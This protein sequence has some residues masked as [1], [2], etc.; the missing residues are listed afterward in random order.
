MQ[1]LREMLGKELNV[2]TVNRALRDFVRGRRPNIVGA[3]HVTCSDETEREIVES[4]QHWFAEPLLPEL[5]FWSRSVF[6]SANLGARYEWGAIRIADEHYDNPELREGQR[7]LAIKLN[8][9]VAVD[10]VG[11]TPVFGKLDR[12]ARQSP[13]CGA[14]HAL[15]EGVRHPAMDELRAAF[16]YDGRDRL[17]MLLDPQIVPSELRSF[18]AAVVNARLQARSAIVDIQSYTPDL[19]TFFVV[20]PCVTLNRAQRDTEFVVGMYWADSRE[21]LGKAHYVG[22]GDDP[23]AY[24]IQHRQMLMIEDD[25]L[26]QPREARDHRQEVV[27]EWRARHAEIPAV[28]DARIEEIARKVRN[29]SLTSARMAQETLKTLLWIAADAAPVPLSVLLFAKGLAGVH[30]LYRVHQL[31]RGAAPPEQARDIIE[32]VADQTSKYTVEQSTRAA[33]AILEH[34]EH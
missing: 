3:V 13:C 26:K 29:D 21:G 30:H 11:T 23:S 1:R 6:R 18:A 7:V 15:L 2:D 25:H 17:A 19:P 32:E 27:T 14:I 28:K 8:S 34:L 16:R 33:R 9:H 31:A 12:Y 24:R 10:R 4:F 22:L 20:L 5:K